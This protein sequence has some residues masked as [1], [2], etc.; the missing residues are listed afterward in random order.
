MCKQY[1]VM[2]TLINAQILIIMKVLL[3]LGSLV[4]DGLADYSLK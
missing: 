3:A 2:K 1:S 4:Q